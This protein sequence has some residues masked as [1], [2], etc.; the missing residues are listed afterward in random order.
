MKDMDCLQKT[1]LAQL[2]DSKSDEMQRVCQEAKALANDLVEYRIGKRNPPPSHTAAI[3][4][5]LS[6]ELEDRHSAVLA[7]M[8]GRLNI[9]TGSAHTK[10]VQVAD[11]VFR[12]GVNWGRIVAIFAFGA[13]LAQYCFRNGLEKEA[14]DITDWVGNYISS[15]SGWILSNGGWE[16]FNQ[17]F[18]E[19]YDERERSWWKKLCLAAVGFGALATLVYQHSS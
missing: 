14:D 17:I 1:R 11:E 8:C 5:R 12:D 9:L 15:L 16:A 6:D 7:N 2:Q 3:L 18:R 10:F 13:K 4:R 19:A